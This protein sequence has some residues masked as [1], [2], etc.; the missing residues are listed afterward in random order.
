MVM[1]VKGQALVPTSY[2]L[3]NSVRAMVWTTPSFY[4]PDG[5]MHS[6]VYLLPWRTWAP[7]VPTT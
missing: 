3:A 2:V 6:T 1:R 4:T 5:G 7:R